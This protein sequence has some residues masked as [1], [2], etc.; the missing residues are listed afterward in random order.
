MKFLMPDI[1]IWLNQTKNGLPPSV[2]RTDKESLF[3]CFTL[4]P[5]IQAVQTDIDTGKRLFHGSLS[6]ILHGHFFCPAPLIAWH[7]V[8][9]YSITSHIIAFSRNFIAAVPLYGIHNAIC[10]ALHNP[11]MV[12]CPVIPPIKEYYIPR[13]RD[14]ACV[15]ELPTGI[16]PVHTVR[17]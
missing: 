10:H 8:S 15:L 6:H 7:T 11:H 9:V 5:S 13:C 14:I 16:E 2:N 4:L 1:F 3:F 17:T 12:N